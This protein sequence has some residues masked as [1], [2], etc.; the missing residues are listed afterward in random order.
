MTL[1]ETLKRIFLGREGEP[2]FAYGL[3]QAA[4]SEAGIVAGVGVPSP[5]HTKLI[6]IPEHVTK[7]SAKNGDIYI[8]GEVTDAVLQAKQDII[9]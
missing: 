5:T 3:S 8:G 6:N 9:Y 7:R 4:C 2:L 1:K